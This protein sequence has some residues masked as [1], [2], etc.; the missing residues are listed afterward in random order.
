MDN[1]PQNAPQKVVSALL[2]ELFNAK[3]SLP[4]LKPDLKQAL[5][6][7]ENA[8][9]LE[10]FSPERAS[11][12]LNAA[13]ET[14]RPLRP[15]VAEKYSADMT[16]GKWTQCLDP[17]TFYDDGNL[18]TGQHRLW[19]VVDSGTTQWF[20]VAYGRP[21]EEGLN[22]DT[23]LPRK[24]ADNAR[25]SGLD[26][27]ISNR[28]ISCVRATEL[29]YMKSDALG[30]PLSFAEMEL[31]VDSHREVGEWLLTHGP[32]GRFVRAGAVMGAIGRAWYYESDKAKLARFCEILN[33][34]LSEGKHESAAISIRNFLLEKG[35]Q[36][37]VSKNWRETF[38]K[39]QNAIKYFMKDYPLSVIKTIS[40]EAYPL[41]QAAVIREKPD[42]NTRTTDA[43][44][45][46][47]NGDKL[48]EAKKMLLAGQSGTEVAK[49]L[50]IS[51]QTISQLKRRLDSD[52]LGL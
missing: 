27:N 22:Y 13:N 30:G 2:L 46:R 7:V 14:N 51:R 33:T 32:K 40:E 29:G 3:L 1:V 45:M 4:A 18:A 15:G 9:F 28:L 24:F 47:R 37:T 26:R 20:Y 38:L 17:I 10:E 5:G 12:I 25:I 16:A 41:R 34:G 44:A 35:T 49:K 50:G 23:G 31:I 6:F 39:V 48:A 19:A 8:L 21:R 43:R 52:G 42:G 36:A 11:R